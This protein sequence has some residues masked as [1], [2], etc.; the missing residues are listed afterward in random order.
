MSFKNIE[1]NKN[2]NRSTKP[3]L[4]T[5]SCFAL[6]VTGYL[7]CCKESCPWIF[8]IQKF[9]WTFPWFVSSSK[10]KHDILCLLTLCDQSFLKLISFW[11]DCKQWFSFICLL[12]IYN[13]ETLWAIC[14]TFSLNRFMFSEFCL[15]FFSKP[16]NISLHM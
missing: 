7:H 3:K 2:N 6:N 4:R 12:I 1:Q 5:S 13:R 15:W 8:E 11:K 9:F 10:M 16:L 14:L